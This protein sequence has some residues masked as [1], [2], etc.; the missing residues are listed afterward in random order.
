[1]PA[2]VAA[3]VPQER[4]F[5]PVLED[6]NESAQ[7]REDEVKNDPNTILFFYI[8][9]PRSGESD[10][11][12]YSMV[13]LT[14]ALYDH[15]D[16]VA[17][18]FDLSNSP[19]HAAVVM[20]KVHRDL[21]RRFPYAAIFDSM[22]PAL[23]WLAASTSDE[24][25]NF[26]HNE[27]LELALQRNV[28]DALME[29]IGRGDWTAQ[30]VPAGRRVEAQVVAKEAAVICGRPWFDA[31]VLALDPRAVV[32]WQATEG[33]A[34]DNGTVVCRIEA[35]AQALLSA[36]RPALNFLQTLSG[37]AT[38][39]R[40]YVDAISGVSP[41]PRGCKV[42]DTRKTL[43]GLRQAQK[44]A[45]R[46]G[47]GHNQRL[48]LWDGILIKENHI[49]AAGSITAAL[50]AARALDAGV[51]IQ[52]EVE[53]IE[54]LKQAL[55]AGATNVLIDDFSLDDMRQAVA[56][57]QGRAVLEVSGGVDLETI[58]EIAA[59]GVDRISVGKLTKDVRAVDLSMRVTG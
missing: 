46:M 39:T 55:D 50:E 38:S 47:G 1:M 37:V 30:L 51:D 36:E 48:A 6:W 58:R 54:E 18:V 15:T 5:N 21:T 34:V 9:N 3:G 56:L 52:I 19:A 59:T 35:D 32:S 2:L 45:V 22:E 12:S 7:Q 14:M 11:S 24:D 44:Y 28:R 29:D 31:C 33:Q 16:R 25:M 13:E 53:S 57:N 49:A 8:G 17:A 4:V 27:T 20:R 26:D 40:R 43:P 23:A 10:L 42:L 41:N